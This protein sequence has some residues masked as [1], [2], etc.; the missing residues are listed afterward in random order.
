MKDYVPSEP[1]EGKSE[2][3]GEKGKSGKRK[4]KDKNAPKGV[5]DMWL[6]IY[7]SFASIRCYVVVHSIFKRGKTT[8]MYRIKGKEVLTH[9]L[10]Y[11]LAVWCMSCICILLHPILRNY[12]LKTSIQRC[13]LLKSWRRRAWGGEL[14][15]QK[16]NCHL[17]SSVQLIRRGENSMR[18]LHD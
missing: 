18:I 10:T 8:G 7:V 16:R 17:K 3:K 6:H 11:W 12:R 4:K 5:V 9:S 1:V 14:W 2:E 13:R 15:Q